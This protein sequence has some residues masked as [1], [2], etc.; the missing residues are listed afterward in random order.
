MRVAKYFITVSALVSCIL[1]VK[2]QETLFRKR[3]CFE[4]ATAFGT[5]SERFSQFNTNAD[6][7]FEGR[8]G[9]HFRRYLEAIAFV[10]YQHKSYLYYAE[11]SGNET[12]LFMDR[13]YV[14]VGVN[15]RLYISDFFFE[16]LKLWKRK[17]K[18]DV[19]LQAG[20]AFTFG[21]DKP[22]SR[23]SDLKNQ[24]YNVPVYRYPYVNDKNKLYFTYLTGLRYNMGE[25]VGLFVEGGLGSLMYAQAGLSVTF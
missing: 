4:F 24:G 23:E 17:D 15:A 11:K 22:D 13:H 3:I 18:W 16:K 19:Y 9:Y 12:L 21:K 6:I 1:V 2:G 7:F 10:G 8:I 5:D 14:P 25:N 20:P